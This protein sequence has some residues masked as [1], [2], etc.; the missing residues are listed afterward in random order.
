MVVKILLQLNQIIAA[1]LGERTLQTV[2]Q[3]HESFCKKKF[4]LNVTR[5]SFVRRCSLFDA[6]NAILL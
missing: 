1:M 4:Y 6:L 3:F 2:E 5:K